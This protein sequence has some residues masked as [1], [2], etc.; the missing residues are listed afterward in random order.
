[1]QVDPAGRHE[2]HGR[3]GL[4]QFQLCARIVG[5]IERAFSDSAMACRCDESGE[6]GIGDRVLVH[7]ETAHSDPVDWSLLW[8][9]MLG[10]HSECAARNPSHP[11]ALRLARE[12]VIN[13]GIIRQWRSPERYL[14]A[15]SLPHLLPRHSDVDSMFGRDKVVQA[16]RRFVDG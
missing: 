5:R 4:K 16:L 2:K 12:F 11:T 13:C 3:T 1:M 15:W 10:T 9:R 14:A 7:P 8:I 6:F